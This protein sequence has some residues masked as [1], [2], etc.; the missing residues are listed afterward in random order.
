VQENFYP[1]SYTNV[2]SVGSLNS[3]D[4]KSDFSTYGKVDVS[5]PGEDILSTKSSLGTAYGY[6]YGN[7]TSFA[8]PFVSALAA[9]LLLINQ[10]ASPQRIRDIIEHT[11][12][13]VGST[14][15]DNQTGWGRVNF[16]KALS[17][18]V[19]IQANNLKTYNWPNPFSPDKDLFTNIT[20]V[21]VSPQDVKI[22]IFDGGGTR[23]WHKDID[24]KDV[25]YGYNT[26]TWDARNMSGTR[27]ANGTYF[28]VVKA[29]STTGKNKISVLY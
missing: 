22:E 10:G 16:V 23:V 11:A 13:D 19:V 25:R 26:I 21:I 29:G 8:A 2:I 4:Q 6:D 15:Y 17:N 7:G 3:T 14:G 1:A 28:Y 24:G 9:H 5:A 27:V 12:D 18:G 20:F